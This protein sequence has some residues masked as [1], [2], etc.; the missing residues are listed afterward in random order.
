MANFIQDT[1]EKIIQIIPAPAGLYSIYTNEAD[2][3]DPIILKVVCLALTDCGNVEFMDMDDFGEI[4][5]AGG[6]FEGTQWREK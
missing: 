6:N 5:M 4:S 3:E 1:D 2:P